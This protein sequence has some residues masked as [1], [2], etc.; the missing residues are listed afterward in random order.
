MAVIGATVVQRKI[1]ILTITPTACC[2]YLNDTRAASRRI[3][4]R[5]QPPHMDVLQVSGNGPLHGQIPSQWKPQTLPL[6]LA[7]LLTKDQCC[8][9]STSA[10]GAGVEILRHVGAELSA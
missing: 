8:A 3:N 2:E 10:I 4:E 9:R 6:D 7:T 5:K 1:R